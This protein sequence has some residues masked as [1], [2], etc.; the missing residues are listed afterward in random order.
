MVDVVYSF[1]VLEESNDDHGVVDD[2]ICWNFHLSVE[3]FI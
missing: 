2:E 3:G 1:A